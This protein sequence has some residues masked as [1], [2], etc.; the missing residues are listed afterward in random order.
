MEK[1]QVKC[2]LVE[3]IGTVKILGDSRSI[4]GCNEATTFVSSN[5]RHMT[6]MQFTIKGQ[7]AKYYYQIFWL[8]LLTYLESKER[9]R[10]LGMGTFSDT[11]AV[12]TLSGAK[13]PALKIKIIFVRLHRNLR[14][15]LF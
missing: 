2:A 3:G 11:Q 5:G 14:S 6:I 8:H 7:P 4:S 10:S 12:L 13:N 1:G 9:N 15:I